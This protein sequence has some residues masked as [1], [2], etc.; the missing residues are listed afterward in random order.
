MTNGTEHEAPHG[1][2]FQQ[3]KETFERYGKC[4]ALAVAIVLVAFAAFSF[5]RRHEA[6]KLTRSMSMLST[7]RSAE[8]LQALL[9]KYPK[10]PAAPLASLRAA[11]TLFNAGKY[12]EAMAEYERFA[13]E[14][15]DH[16]LAVGADLGRAHRGRFR[17]TWPT[18]GPRHPGR[19]CSAPRAESPDSDHRRGRTRCPNWPRSSRNSR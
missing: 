1:G 12:D 16:N 17:R 4:A 9:S 3:L 15:P 7:A 19:T 14:F 13:R 2:E 10:T 6:A 18:I 5:Y 11:K 8:D